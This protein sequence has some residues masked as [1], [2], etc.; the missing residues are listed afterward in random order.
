MTR[1]AR[2]ASL[3]ILAGLAGLAVAAC[4]TAPAPAQAPVQA[5]YWS[6]EGG[7]PPVDP[8]SSLRQ[9]GPELHAAH[10]AFSRRAMFVLGGWAVLNLAAGTAGRALTTGRT[11]YFHEMNAAWNTVNLAI[12]GFSLLNLQ[13][14]GYVSLPNTLREAQNLD[15]FL[16][17]NAGLD[18][19]Y[20][21]TG[22]FLI[23]RGMRLERDRLVGYG[24]SLLLQGGFLLLFDAALFALHRPLTAEILEQIVLAPTLLH[25]FGT[26]VPV[27][28]FSTL[29]A[30]A[31]LPVPAALPAL[32]LTLRF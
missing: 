1:L 11:R 30:P 25:P 24:R 13:D 10:T 15:T 4:A 26:A 3:A 31:A 2:H 22:G 14:A 7:V 19:A 32:S 18:V 29:S 27:E 20:I 5:L 6:P 17:L 12:A 23:E 9:A 16:L 28:A 21:A 8:P